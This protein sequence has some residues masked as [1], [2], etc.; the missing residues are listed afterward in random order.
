MPGEDMQDT[1][2]I[3]IVLEEERDPACPDG[4]EL[5][6]TDNSI[7][8]S[9]PIMVESSSI[10]NTYALFTSYQNSSALVPAYVFAQ[11][12]HW[13]ASANARS[14]ASRN[15]GSS[16]EMPRSNIVWANS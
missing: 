13:I 4:L 14:S 8:A 9:E 10:V 16:W 5:W 2:V 1:R 11:R 6:Q 3:V 12:P 7:A 15:E